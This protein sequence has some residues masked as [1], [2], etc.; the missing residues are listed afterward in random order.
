QPHRTRD[1]GA[2]NQTGEERPLLPDSGVSRDGGPRHVRQCEMVEAFAAR[3]A[4]RSFDA[5]AV[6]SAFAPDFARSCPANSHA[7]SGRAETAYRRW[8]RPGSLGIE[9]DWE[10]IT[11]PSM[12]KRA[13]NSWLGRPWA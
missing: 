3:L 7:L 8:Q 13:A 4:E 9:T 5:G 10:E 1:L 2:R 11:W 6:T 12:M